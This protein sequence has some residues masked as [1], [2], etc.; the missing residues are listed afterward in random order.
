MDDQKR[1]ERNCWCSVGESV[2]SAWSFGTH[3]L[4]EIRS[5]VCSA[6]CCYTDSQCQLL[7]LGGT[8]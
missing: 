4:G 3:D 5:Y 8:C 7:I 6:R 2:T 1:Y